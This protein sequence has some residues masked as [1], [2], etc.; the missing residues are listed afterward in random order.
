M[1]SCS[2]KYYSFIHLKAFQN[3]FKIW[4]F[5]MFLSK[6]FHLI[7]IF[8]MIYEKIIWMHESNPNKK[9]CTTINPF[10]ELILIQGSKILP[11]IRIDPTAPNQ[12]KLCPLDHNDP[13]YFCQNCRPNIEVARR[14]W[15]TRIAVAQWSWHLAGDLS[16]GGSNPG[17]DPTLTPLAIFDPAGGYKMHKRNLKKWFPAKA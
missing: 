16:V 12:P 4:E 5:G 13:F 10:F 11:I 1:V 7:F 15:N 8:I 9:I 17:R 14:L 6:S 2:W 3:D